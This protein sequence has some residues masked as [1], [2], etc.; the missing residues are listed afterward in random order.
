MALSDAKV[1]TSKVRDKIYKVSDGRGLYI[2]VE[3]NGARLWRYRYILHG[4]DKRIALGAY[5]IADIKPLEVL[6]ALEKFEKKGHQEAARWC[7]SSVRSASSS[8]DAA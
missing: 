6:A 2:E 8:K 7:R 1:R 5:P 4:K 3:P